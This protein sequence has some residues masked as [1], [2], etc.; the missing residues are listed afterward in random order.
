MLKKRTSWIERNLPTFH[1]L[2]CNQEEP[3]KEYKKPECKDVSL[4]EAIKILNKNKA[5]LDVSHLH[6]TVVDRLFYGSDHKGLIDPEKMFYPQDYKRYSDCG[7]SE[8]L[9]KD[10][11]NNFL[12]KLYESISNFSD[13]NLDLS[14]IKRVQN[15]IDSKKESLANFELSEKVKGLM[16]KSNVLRSRRTGRYDFA[17]AAEAIVESGF[18]KAKEKIRTSRRSFEE[19]LKLWENVATGIRLIAGREYTG[20]L[21]GDV[22]LDIAEGYIFNNNREGSSNVLKR[23]KEKL[24]ITKEYVIKHKEKLKRKISIMSSGRTKR[25]VDSVMDVLF[26]SGVKITDEDRRRH[27]YKMRYSEA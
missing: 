8:V 22:F 1:K 7:I 27:S 9:D 26:S 15:Y 11:S 16:T 12:E 18:Q 14:I 13:R 24:G 6:N 2:L 4:E 17:S 21:K 5:H 23:M 19:K 10:A 25:A 3:K 20:D